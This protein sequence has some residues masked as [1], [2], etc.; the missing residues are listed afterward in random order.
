MAAIAVEV[1]KER[2]EKQ[3]ET[4]RETKGKKA[5]KAAEAITQKIV[6]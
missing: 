4:Q 6:R 2:R 3:A 1:D 5:V